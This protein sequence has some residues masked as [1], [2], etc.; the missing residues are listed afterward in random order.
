MF[1][2]LV[3]TSPESR[4]DTALHT[5]IKN[6]GSLVE[7]QNLVRQVGEEQAACMAKT[8]NN[9]GQLPLDLSYE[10]IQANLH[11][12]EINI[13]LAYLAMKYPI[14]PLGEKI[15]SA[16]V[17]KTYGN[18]SFRFNY[19]LSLACALVNAVRHKLKYSDTHPQTNAYSIER[20]K[21][22]SYEIEAHR[23]SAYVS[24][25]SIYERSMSPC[26][27]DA[28]REVVSSYYS[29][30]TQADNGNCQ[31]FSFVGMHIANEVYQY[32]RVEMFAVSK[33]DH[34]FL[35]LDRD[36]NS[37][38]SNYASWGE[39][40][41]VCDAWSGE[42]FPAAKIPEKLSTYKT[43]G[44]GD[45]YFNVIA[46][47]NPHYHAIKLKFSWLPK[48]LPDLTVVKTDDP[49]DETVDIPD[50]EI[51]P[52]QLRLIEQVNRF[53][54]FPPPNQQPINDR[55]ADF[56]VKEDSDVRMGF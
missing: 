14:K 11:R 32:N 42:V 4:S 22:L 45:D 52:T 47:F 12:Q 48:V 9:L 26:S 10:S 53:G 1:S 36:P 13:R 56:E 40:A 17:L 51:P 24:A 38:G 49:M 20:K 27:F 8:V 5:L 21:Q 44:E 43:Y 37:D 39:N 15:N 3:Y 25:E 28:H 34:V 55:V 54:V 33:G 6:N 30:A 41:V 46:N 7:L 19:N 31:E 50:A 16:D 35:V 29:H 18:Q 23:D 2:Q